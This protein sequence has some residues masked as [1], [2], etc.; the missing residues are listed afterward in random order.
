MGDRN[1]SQRSHTVLLCL[2][3]VAMFGFAF[4]LVPLY[5][6]VCEL[7]GLNGKTSGRSVTAT[8]VAPVSDREVTIQF[9][10]H[11]TRGMPSEFRPTEHRLRVRLGEVHTTHYYVRNHAS[12]GVV[13]QAVP[14]VAPSVAARY[15]HKIECFC[16]TQQPLGGGEEKQMPVQFYV[17]VD[18]PEE[19]HT[20]SLS[21]TLFRVADPKPQTDAAVTETGPV[22]TGPRRSSP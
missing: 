1:N 15:L 19:V 22:G 4:A 13:G 12:E 18:L 8:Q 9:L 17:G 3:A 11:V 6:L 2:L 5:T 16:F 7:T 14:S 20:L 10:A 21:Y